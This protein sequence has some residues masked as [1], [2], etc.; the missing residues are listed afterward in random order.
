MVEEVRLEVCWRCYTCVALTTAAAVTVVRTTE[1][2]L[3]ARVPMVTSSKRTTRLVGV[4]A[5]SKR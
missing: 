5:S 4:G 1:A 2:M 3:F